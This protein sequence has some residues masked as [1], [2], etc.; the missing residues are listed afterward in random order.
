MAMDVLDIWI[1][2]FNLLPFDP[3][4]LLAPPI[5][6]AYVRERVNEKL[7]LSLVKFLPSV[8]YVW[9]WEPF[10]TAFWPICITAQPF[11]TIPASLIA[12][13]WKNSVAASLFII[14]EKSFLLNQIEYFP[15]YGTNGILGSTAPCSIIIDPASILNGASICFSIIAAATPLDKDILPRAFFYAFSALTVT[16]TG[17]DT[18]PTPAGPLPLIITSCPVI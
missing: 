15:T 10:L 5:I 11:I 4:G 13:A 16:I 14:S 1:D 8:I 9:A 7:E 3:T 18:T 6:T 2:Q 12:E 17:V